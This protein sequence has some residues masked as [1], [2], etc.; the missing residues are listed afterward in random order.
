VDLIESVT[1]LGEAVECIRGLRYRNDFAPEGG[2][3]MMNDWS[4]L[5]GVAHYGHSP[6]F[7]AYGRAA[8]RLGAAEDHLLGLELL[9][10]DGN[11]SLAPHSLA[12]SAIEATGRATMLLDPQLSP[13]ERAGLGFAERLEEIEA[14][15]RFVPAEA[16]DETDAAR[17]YAVVDEALHAV[18]EEAQIE[19]I[20]IG[21]YPRFTEAFRVALALPGDPLRGVGVAARYSG[22]AHSLTHAL[23]D[24][25]S[26]GRKGRPHPLH[27][28]FTTLD[29]DSVL[30]LVIVPL[31]AFASAVSLQV[32]AYGWPPS[33]WRRWTGHAR[34]VL[35]RQL[36][37]VGRGTLKDEWRDIAADEEGFDID[38]E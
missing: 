7:V 8:A 37:E 18:R 23:I 34:A 14:L 30:D 32:E 21:K 11:T 3:Q 1:L 13:A 12:R 36:T 26:I 19:G 22:I 33:V 6:V 17:R 38:M 27:V 35:R 28:G 29:A 24:I 5:P 4:A 31:G 16:Q 9:L 25:A 15:R 10:R 20:T 2:H